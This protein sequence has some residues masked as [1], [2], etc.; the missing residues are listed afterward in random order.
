MKFDQNV[1][2][3]STHKLQHISEDSS[4]KLVSKTNLLDFECVY[5]RRLGTRPVCI[6]RY[7]RKF[8]FFFYFS[9]QKEVREEMEEEPH[10]VSFA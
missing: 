2:S 3:I 5:T 8:G 9:T 1:Y 6:S 4:Q 7:L 10:G